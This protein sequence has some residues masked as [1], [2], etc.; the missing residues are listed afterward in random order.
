MQ[1][2]CQWQLKV[3]IPVGCSSWLVIKSNDCPGQSFTCSLISDE[4]TDNWIVLLSVCGAEKYCKSN[5][6]LPDKGTSQHRS[7]SL[8]GSPGNYSADKLHV[9]CFSTHQK[10]TFSQ[11]RAY[12]TL[13]YISISPSNQPS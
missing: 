13:K 7:F 2:G 11:S 3:S 4:T 1:T 10:V 9:N 6:K 5:K 8:Y 12:Q